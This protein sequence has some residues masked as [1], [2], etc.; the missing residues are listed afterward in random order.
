M[1]FSESQ[2]FLSR[3]ESAPATF[4]CHPKN[5]ADSVPLGRALLS[6]RTDAN[7]FWMLLS[8]NAEVAFPSSRS[9]SKKRGTKPSAVAAAAGTAARASTSLASAAKIL[10]SKSRAR[11]EGRPR[12]YED[13]D[14]SP[15]LTECPKLEHNPDLTDIKIDSKIAV[16]RAGD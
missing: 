9:Q 15:P 4:S 3:D 6:A 12:S 7:W 5:T 16:Y 8:G 14:E 13:P 10:T 2:S 1:S 11:R